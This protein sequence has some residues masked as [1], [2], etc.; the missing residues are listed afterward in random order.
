MKIQVDQDG[1]IVNWGLEP[2]S[3]QD[4]YPNSQIITLDDW[5][6]FDETKD[7]YWVDGQVN[8]RDKPLEIPAPTIEE[9]MANVEALLLDMILNT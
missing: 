2:W 4:N 9:R 3:T 7:N 6:P 1:R 5:F 8:V